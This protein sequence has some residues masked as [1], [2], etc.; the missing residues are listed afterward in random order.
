MY[1]R[2][3]VHIYVRMCICAEPSHQ[4]VELHDGV[5]HCSEGEP[6]QNNALLPAVHPSAV[7]VCNAS[8]AV[9]RHEG[10]GVAYQVH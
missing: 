9:K 1:L 4:E 5:S 10:F 3:Y 6:N 8:S 7:G 2:M